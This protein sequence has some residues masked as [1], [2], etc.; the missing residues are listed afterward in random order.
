MTI[1]NTSGVKGFVALNNPKYFN[2]IVNQLKAF[3]KAHG[4]GNSYYPYKAAYNSMPS[5]AVQLF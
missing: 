2:K 5:H 1:F 4:L 3:K